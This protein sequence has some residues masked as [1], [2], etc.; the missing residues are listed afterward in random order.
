ME[1]LF[2]IWP[3]VWKKAY[4]IYDHAIKYK[5]DMMDGEVFNQFCWLT[6]EAASDPSQH[7]C[8][9]TGI[10]V[11]ISSTPLHTTLTAHQFPVCKPDCTRLLSLVQLALWC[12]PLICVL[13]IQ[14][15]HCTVV[16]WPQFSVH[17]SAVATPE[18]SRQIPA[19]FHSV[20]LRPF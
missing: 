9:H 8:N 11:P 19:R 1:Q 20:T 18:Q 14:S 6:W 13:L 4:F 10:H 7:R 2:L 3:W 15:L 5:D 17:C 16:L 12:C